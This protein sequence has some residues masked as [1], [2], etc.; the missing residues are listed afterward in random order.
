MHYLQ[1]WK[2]DGNWRIRFRRPGYKPVELP[3]P[4]GYRGDKA[5]L[6]NSTEFL[7]AYLSA[8]AE[9]VAE[10]APGDKR[11]AY[12]TVDW[13]VAEYLGS[14]DFK[15]RPESMREKIKR[16]VEG[17][18]EKCGDLMVA[19][20]EADHIEKLFAKMIDTPMKANNGSTH[21]YRFAYAIKR[22]LLPINPAAEI[23]KRK[24]EE[25]GMR[26]GRHGAEE[27]H[28]TWSRSRRPARNSRSAPRCGSPSN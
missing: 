5:T 18:G 3:V 25:Y 20:I 17:F 21:A 14:L 15:E 6:G 4:R 27:G 2:Q 23:K 11:A 19:V 10:I 7:T 1:Q 26:R 8:M 13:L 12:G 28:H 22:K 24:P 16:S 9:P